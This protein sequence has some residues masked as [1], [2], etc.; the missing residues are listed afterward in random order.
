MN[1]WTLRMPRFVS[2]GLGAVADMAEHLAGLEGE[3]LI[4]TDRGVRE[5]GLLE[6]VQKLISEAG[7]SP[8]VFDQLD[9]QPDIET[10]QA[11]VDRVNA[12]A[13]AAIVAVGGG[14]V[15]DPAKIMAV[16]ARN[17]GTVRDVVQ[18][19]GGG[20]G[21]ERQINAAMPLFTVPTMVSGA[22][23]VP[24]GVVTDRA[25]HTK[26]ANWSLRMMPAATFVDPSYTAS[27]PHD[28][29]VDAALDSFTHALEGLTVKRTTPIAQQLAVDAAT[30]IYRSLPIIYR[31]SE[32]DE[33][34]ADL[35]LGCMEAGMV[36][37][38]TRAAAVHGLS[39]P[40]SASFPITHGRSLAV[41]AP[42]VTRFNGPAAEREYA[43][44]VSALGISQT[45]NPGEALAAAIEDLNRRVGVPDTLADIGA[46]TQSIPGLVEGAERN[47]WFFDNNPRPLARSD[48]EALYTQALVGR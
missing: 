6:P 13:F 31:S 41:L 2:F 8:Q 47:S 20:F 37:A 15:I 45:D 34:R 27:A 25:A 42:A 35:T 23:F 3:I 29:L 9:E 43:H 16:L 24:A 4:V 30:R 11:A 12:G 46:T 1:A 33:A 21:A 22:D 44:L 38:N 48:I 7:L 32:D 14:S 18:W 39:Y 17:K 5:A 10:I 28:V 36:I 19:F 26:F 40:V